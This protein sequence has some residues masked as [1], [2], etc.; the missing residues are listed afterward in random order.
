MNARAPRRC[1]Q[2]ATTRLRTGDGSAKRTLQAR[3]DV[4]A[5]EPVREAFAAVVNGIHQYP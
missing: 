4:F 5:A 3:V 2:R 1:E